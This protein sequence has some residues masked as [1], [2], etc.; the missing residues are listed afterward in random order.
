M[1]NQ[2]PPEVTRLFWG[3]D[4]SKLDWQNHQKYIIQ[5]ILDKGDE[6]AVRW[7][8]QKIDKTKLKSQ[9]DQLSL[10]PKSKNFWKLYL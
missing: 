9:L 1:Q 3:D 2:F 6:K 7:L 5:T 8:F 10:S 4:L